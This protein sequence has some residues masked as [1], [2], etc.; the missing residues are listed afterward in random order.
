MIGLKKKKTNILTAAISLV[1]IAGIS[2]AGG[3]GASD[4]AEFDGLIEPHL[5]V[6]VGSSVAG[7]LKSVSV[8]RGDMVEK[9]QLLAKIRSGVERAIIGCLR[10]G[11]GRGGA[12]D[13]GPKR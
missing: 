5:M 1:C 10:G 2:F 4:T 7:V 13:S 11:P 8:D 3:A 6:E 9:G 12:G